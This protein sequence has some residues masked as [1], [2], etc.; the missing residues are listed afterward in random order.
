[1]LRSAGHDMMYRSGLACRVRRLGVCVKTYKSQNASEQVQTRW[2]S[3]DL[4]ATGSGY[5]LQEF[6]V[7]G[8]LWCDIECLVS[9]QFVRIG[10]RAG[11]RFRK[12][13]TILCFVCFIL[14]KVLCLG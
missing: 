14:K 13:E 7:D 10:L 5:I 4:A 2:M 1:M 6:E 9:E 12:L 11:K 8:Y 3:T